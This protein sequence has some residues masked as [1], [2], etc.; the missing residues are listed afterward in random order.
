[1]KNF[2]KSQK[3]QLLKVISNCLAYKL[4]NIKCEAIYTNYLKDNIKD[5]RNH[6]RMKPEHVRHGLTANEGGVLFAVKHIIE[7]F[8]YKNYGLKEVYIPKI[9]D[10]LSVRKTIFTAYS[11]VLNYNKE[12][13]KALK[14]IDYSEVLKMD[15]CDLVQTDKNGIKF[16]ELNAIN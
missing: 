5:E 3:I 16:E 12:I 9:E 14:N 6:L 7:F 10:Y 4:D 8:Q 13:K 1:M 11:I 2:T 15:Y